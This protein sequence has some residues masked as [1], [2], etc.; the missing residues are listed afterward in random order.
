MKNTIKF[1]GAHRWK[2]CAIAL[3]AVIGFAMIACDADKK[4]DEGG[5]KWLGTGSLTITNEQVY[6]VKQ[7]VTNYVYE[8]YAGSDKLTSTGGSGDITSGKLTYTVSVPTDANLESLEGDEGY[9][10]FTNWDKVKIEPKTVKTF[11]FEGA[12]TAS[13]KYVS[14]SEDK[15]K[16]SGSSVSGSTE[17]VMYVYVNAD[18]KITGEGKTDTDQDEEGKYTITTKNLSLSLKKGWNAVTLKDT[19][20][21]TMSDVKFTTSISVNNPNL[22]WTLSEYDDDY[23]EDYS[24]SIPSFNRLRQNIDN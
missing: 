1:W 16:I 15:T 23:D 14:K 6:T 13:D 9:S 2:L 11:L 10:W 24:W 8:K 3:A 18:V 22:K 5:K 4:T 17:S 21:G 20:S 12:E 7:T 19:I